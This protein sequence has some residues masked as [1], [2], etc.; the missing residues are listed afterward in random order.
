MCH[1]KIIFVWAVKLLTEIIDG[2]AAR[3][4]RATGLDKYTRFMLIVCGNVME[5]V[6]RCTKDVSFSRFGI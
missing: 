6:V 5:M 1:L 4:F 3:K 2:T